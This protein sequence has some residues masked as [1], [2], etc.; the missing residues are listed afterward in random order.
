MQFFLQ[1]LIFWGYFLQLSELL[2]HSLKLLVRT[3]YFY[4]SSLIFFVI[5]FLSCFFKILFA[6]LDKLCQIFDWSHFLFVVLLIDL[7]L[8]NFKICYNFVHA[9]LFFFMVFI[10]HAL[11]SDIGVIVHAFIYLL[12]YNHILI[13]ERNRCSKM[14]ILDIMKAHSFFFINLGFIL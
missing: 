9:H 7:S 14:L 5:F 1:F 3:F 4:A 13:L 8:L 2:L 10:G 12:P 11:R 6:G